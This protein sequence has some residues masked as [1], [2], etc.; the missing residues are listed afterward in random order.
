MNES[1]NQRSKLLFAA[2]RLYSWH[3]HRC[4]VYEVQI[5]SSSPLMVWL[6]LMCS[7]PH[8]LARLASSFRSFYCRIQG[9]EK[10]S[11]ARRPH[12]IKFRK[13]DFMLMQLSVYYLQGARP[14]QNAQL[15]FS[16]CRVSFIMLKEA[17]ASC[18]TNN[19]Q[20]I[21]SFQ[22][23]HFQTPHTTQWNENTFSPRCALLSCLVKHNASISRISCPVQLR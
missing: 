17:M 14:W 19:K 22:R 18:C 3:W 11:D 1:E 2:T 16:S 20:I 4:W 8:S 12:V 15:W 7:A 9:G 10:W 13:G 21:H 6:L 5:G 23:G